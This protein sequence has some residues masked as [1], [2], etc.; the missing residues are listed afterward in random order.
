MNVN[1]IK[2]K[3]L[4]QID[5]KLEQKEEEKQITAHWFSKGLSPKSSV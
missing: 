4:N 3:I 1:E 5:K 2:N